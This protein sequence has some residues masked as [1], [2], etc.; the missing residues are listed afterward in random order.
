M[1]FGASLLDT[2]APHRNKEATPVLRD[3]G[4]QVLYLPPY[5][6]GLNP[7]EQAISKLKVHL[8]GIGARPF[9][10]VFQAIWR[11]PQPRADRAL[12]RLQSSRLCLKLISKRFI[13]ARA[14]SPKNRQCATAETHLNGPT[15]TMKDQGFGT[16]YAYDQEDGFLGQNYFPAGVERPSLYAPGERGFERDLKKRVDYFARLRIDRQKA[17]ED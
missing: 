11:N 8:G 15:R 6:P 5:S 1:A 12:E 16:G 7:I 3:R 13:R 9:P 17:A 10:A 14:A 4:C 2:P